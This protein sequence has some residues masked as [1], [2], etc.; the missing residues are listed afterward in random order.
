METAAIYKL[1]SPSGKCYVGQTVNLR[2]RLSRYK[3]ASCEGQPYIYNAIKKYG[4]DNF[5]VEILYQTET[6]F[7]HLGV[8]LDTLET[9]WINKY[10]CINNGYNL[11]Q[12]GA[13]GYR[14]SQKTKDKISEALKGREVWNTGLST[15]TE[16][17]KKALRNKN[18]KA[19]LQY[20]K[21]GEFIREWFSQ[22]DVKR[23]LNISTSNCLRG[24]RKTAGGFC[25]KFKEMEE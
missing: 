15:C 5:K 20:T 2:K 10:D 25:W 3:N 8:L 14:H 16:E 23:A 17:N 19:I 7:T 1:E 12:G 13:G 22:A 9:A 4:F 11:M 21:D 18:S 6:E 24:L